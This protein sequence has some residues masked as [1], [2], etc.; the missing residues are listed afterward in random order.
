MK[1]PAEYP[2]DKWDCGIIIS[3][4]RKNGAPC[5]ENFEL[6]LDGAVEYWGQDYVPSSPI[7]AQVTANWASGDIVICVEVNC[8]FGVSCYRCLEKT[9]IA[10]KGEM[11]YIFSLRQPN[12]NDDK[13]FGSMDGDT[14]EPDGTEDVIMIEP[15]KA[16]IDM[17]PYIW[18]TM[19]LNLPQRVLCAKDCRGVCPNCGSNRNEEE[20]GCAEDDSDPRLEVLKKLL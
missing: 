17:A 2:A 4:I 18:E 19:I 16:E 11:R 14:G 20:C 13:T 15:H 8:E 5:V 6:V 10:I 12:P 9:G 3:E 1:K 7:R